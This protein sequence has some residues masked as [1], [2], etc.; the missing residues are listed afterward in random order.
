MVSLLVGERVVR[1][2]WEAP[3]FRQWSARAS[4]SPVFAP[5]IRIVLLRK[6]WG[7]GRG[8]FEYLLW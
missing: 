2:R 7:G 8:G 1:M 4:P 6:V 3:R 5:V